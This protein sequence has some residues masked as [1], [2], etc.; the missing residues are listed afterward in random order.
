[1]NRFCIVEWGGKP[2]PA[3]ILYSL[4][5]RRSKADQ[6]DC[7]LDAKRVLELASKADLLYVS[8]DSFEKAKLA[9]NVA[10]E[11]LSGC[12]KYH[13]YLQ[14][15]LRSHLQTGQNERMVGPTRRF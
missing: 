7:A 1:M 11:L 12:R 10:F 15:S 9:Q 14:I 3:P 4:T 13:A 6:G 5:G 2:T 8:H